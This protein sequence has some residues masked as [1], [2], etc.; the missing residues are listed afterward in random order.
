MLPLHE[1]FTQFV[2]GK[3]I[4]KCVT[5]LEKV[6]QVGEPWRALTYDFALQLLQQKKRP[7]TGRIS[8]AV[9][10]GFNPLPGQRCRQSKRGEMKRDLAEAD[11]C[12]CQ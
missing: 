8:P 5:D 7:G 6:S 12:S 11:C 4:M 10:L 3:M 2:K 1:A 9:L